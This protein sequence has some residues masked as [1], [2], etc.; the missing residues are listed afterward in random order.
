MECIGFVA[1]MAVAAPPYRITTI[2]AVSGVGSPIKLDVFFF[3]LPLATSPTAGAFTYAELAQRQS[4]PLMRGTVLD[5]LSRAARRR[6]QERLKGDGDGDPSHSVAA[7]EP[8]TSATPFF[9]NQ[10]TTVLW[11]SNG[12]SVNLKLFRNGRVQMTGLTDD[13]MGREAVASLV[14]TLRTS[15]MEAV[16]APEQL[17]PEPY[18]VCLITADKRLGFHVRRDRLVHVVQGALDAGCEYEPTLYPGV[19]IKFMHNT[20]PPSSDTGG[21]NCT[22]PC[23]GEGDGH[24]DGQCRKVTIMVFQSGSVII[25]GG[26]SG[27]HMDAAHQFLMKSVVQ[28]HR[29]DIERLDAPL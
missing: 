14:R 5:G 13:D 29:A 25:T 17:N 19:K 9:S 12:R 18:R 20:G 4:T 2:T 11:L 23:A 28:P 24:G 22:V 26:R 1:G 15:S 27:A 3:G 21:C 10:V 8:A 16:A 6:L 7:V